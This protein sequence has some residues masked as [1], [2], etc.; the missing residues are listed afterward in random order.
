MLTL[1][2]D[3]CQLGASWRCEQQELRGAAGYL[4]PLN[5]PM[6]RT[7]MNVDHGV[8]RIEITE[9]CAGTDSLLVE[10]DVAGIRFT[11][12]TGGVCPLYLIVDGSVLRGSWNPADLLSWV[13]PTRL[14]DAAVTRLLTRRQRYSANTMFDGLCKVTERATVTADLNGLAVAYPEPAEHVIQARELR[15]GAEP[16]SVFGRLL[17][18]RVSPLAAAEE[19]ELAVE[20]SGGLDSA[21][22]ATSMTRVGGLVGLRS[23][24][25]QVDGG[26]GEDQGARRAA[27]ARRLGLRDLEVS[28]SAYL[29]FAAGGPRSVENPHY[30]DGDVYAEAFDQLRLRLHDGGAQ[31]VVTGFGG[32]ELMALRGSERGSGVAPLPPDLPSWLGERALDAMPDLDANIAPVSPVPVS[33]LM[34]FAARNPAYIRYGLWPV[35]P[36]ADSGLL[37]LCESLPVAWRRDK[38]LFRCYLG[39]AG[40]D[41]RVTHPDTVES[42]QFVMERAMRRTG[43][44]MIEQMLDDSILVDGGYVDRRPLELL[45]DKLIRDRAIPRL[46]YDTLAVERSLQSVR[47]AQQRNGMTR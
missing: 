42:F 35:A 16:V 44:L 32:D 2:I 15:V 34:V 36:L 31:V 7:R 6:T 20:I 5:H 27:I 23:A 33:A 1:E 22:V 9:R 26:I 21:T 14:V 30:A 25:L 19:L 3:L 10:G 4:S 8:W 45:R 41:Q 12:G 37:R 28:A 38:A 11:A 47:H 29:P 18:Q 24:G 43:R 40:F 17:A 46:L 13:S 39:R